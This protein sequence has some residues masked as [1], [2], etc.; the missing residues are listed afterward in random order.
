MKEKLKKFLFILSILI[1]IILTTIEIL[2]I[3]DPEVGCQMQSQCIWFISSELEMKRK[4]FEVTIRAFIPIIL[5]GIYLIIYTAKSKNKAKILLWLLIIFSFSIGLYSIVTNYREAK[6]IEKQ[7]EE[8]GNS[9][10]S[11]K[12][13]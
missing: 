12:N 7:I 11:Y 2:E 1:L 13:A 8:N 6:Q 10:K 3:I 5:L 4:Q 9:I